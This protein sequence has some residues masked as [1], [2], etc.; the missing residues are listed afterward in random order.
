MAA[1]Y[2]TAV[3]SFTTK[4]AGDT[5]QGSHINDVQDEVAAIEGGL[6][7]GTA[8]LNSSNSTLANLS[9]PGVSTFTGN[10]TMAGT[11]TVNK[12]VSTS[13]TVN[14]VATYVKAFLSSITEHSSGASTAV[15]GLDGRAVDL[16][17]EYDSTTFTF[18]PKSSGYYS[19]V[20]RGYFPTVNGTVGLK[21]TVNST[22]VAQSVGYVLGGLDAGICVPTLLHLSSGAAGAVQLQYS[23]NNGS[24][25]QLSTGANVTTLEILRVF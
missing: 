18:T 4:S 14:S 16:S 25:W 17:S 7:N 6:L 3:K 23:V 22:V 13:L 24:T 9:V 1:S 5:I 2:P 12:I 21:L 10:V 19:V 15:I 11:L 20:A 8:P